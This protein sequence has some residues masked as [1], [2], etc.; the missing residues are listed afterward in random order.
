[1]AWSN[2]APYHYEMLETLP[3]L[4]R[5][6]EAY[7]PLATT[8][9]DRS[10]LNPALPTSGSLCYNHPAVESTMNSRTAPA[11]ADSD[12]QQQD[13]EHPMSFCPVCSQRLESKRCKLVCKTCGY[14]LSC[15]D[16]C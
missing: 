3:R 2:W 1:M 6:K 11:Q 9:V 14:Y 7:T 5:R 8:N 12:E 15:S 16:Y 4:E 10:H 13:I